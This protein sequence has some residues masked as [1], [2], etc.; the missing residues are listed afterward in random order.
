MTSRIT[1]LTAY[2][3]VETKEIG[4]QEVFKCYECEVTTFSPT[5]FICESSLKLCE[6]RTVREKLSDLLSPEQCQKFHVDG[7]GG[8]FVK[9][10]DNLILTLNTWGFK[11]PPTMLGLDGVQMDADTGN[12]D[13][14][15]VMVI[16]LDQAAL[17]VMRF[18]EIFVV[19]LAALRLKAISVEVKFGVIWYYA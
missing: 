14:D 19:E 5:C 9:E 13:F 8:E 7:Y 17:C 2:A 1:M 4:T 12:Y 6:I 3:E 16:D 15:G 11:T 10:H 18:D